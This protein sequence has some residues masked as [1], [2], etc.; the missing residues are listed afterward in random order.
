MLRQARPDV[1]LVSMAA[2]GKS[3]AD[4]DLVGF[5]PVI[6]LM[7]GLCSLTGYLDE[8]EPFKTGISY[9]DPGRRHLRRRRRSPSP[10]PERQRTGKGAYIDLAQ[11][12]GAAVLGRRGLRGRLAPGRHH[13]AAT[14]ATAPT[15]GRRRAPTGAPATT[16]GSWWRW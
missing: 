10:W 3:G 12:E 15:A 14:S 16:S 8:D 11:R 6:E 7:S 9:G 4:Q 2:F 13:A 5:G 1:I